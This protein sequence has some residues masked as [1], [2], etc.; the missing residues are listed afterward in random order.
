MRHTFRL[1]I[2]KVAIRFFPPLII[3]AISVWSLNVYGRRVAVSHPVSAAEAVTN[4]ETWIKAH[5]KDATGYCTLGRVHALAW[6]YGDEIPLVRAGEALGEAVS[7]PIFSEVSTVLVSR[8]GPGEITHNIIGG[9]RVDFAA[10]RKDRAVSAD[11]AAHLASSIAA[12]RKAIELDANDALSELGLSWMIAQQGIYALDLPADYWGDLK[13]TDAEKLSWSKAIGQLADDDQKVRDAAS[14]TLLAAMPRCTV[15][16]RDAKPA[17]P[18]SKGRIGAVLCDHFELQALEHY[19]KAFELRKAE[20]LK[21]EPTFEADS[22]ISAKAGA[23]ILTLLGKHPEAA[24][25]DEV[26]TVQGVLDP[27][28]KKMEHLSS[29]PQ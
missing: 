21:G 20:D 25:K 11:D 4:T 3:L 2:P 27:L 7:L 8:T 22:Q 5:P 6:A 10:D 9:S 23:Q 12:Y 1:L 14:K 15:A 16:L 24:H 13:P 29:M 26:K 19:R 28:A 17:D 18:E